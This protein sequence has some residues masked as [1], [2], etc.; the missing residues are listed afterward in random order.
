MGWEGVFSYRFRKHWYQNLEE[1]LLR[2]EGNFLVSFCNETSFC[3]SSSNGEWSKI[4]PYPSFL[5]AV[6]AIGTAPFKFFQ[7]WH[8]DFH[9]WFIH[10]SWISIHCPCHGPCHGEPWIM[11]EAWMAGHGVTTWN[12]WRVRIPGRTSNFHKS[13]LD[14]WVRPLR[15]FLTL[16][17]PEKRFASL[18]GLHWKTSLLF[19]SNI[20]LLD[21][22]HILHVLENTTKKIFK[23]RATT[24]S[25]PPLLDHSAANILS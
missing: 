24:A 19:H 16:L 13:R 15:R 20:S 5:K 7:P 9:L 8:M 6:L 1:I 23:I 12:E 14:K 21:Y 22:S 17:V 11:D 4:G 25:R 2:I 10:Y 18:K 3:F